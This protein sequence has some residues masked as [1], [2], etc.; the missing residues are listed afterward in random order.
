MALSD[1]VVEAFTRTDALGTRRGVRVAWSAPENTET[2]VRWQFR[3]DPG[4]WG[5]WEV[6]GLLRSSPFEI[7]PALTGRYELQVLDQQ[8]GRDVAD[9][10]FFEVPVAALVESALE[11]P[12]PSGLELIGPSGELLGSAVAFT[13]RDLKIRWNAVRLDALET[14]GLGEAPPDQLLDVLE[15]RIVGPTG[16]LLR[17][18]LLPIEA[19]EWAYTYAANSEDQ[20]LTTDPASA[21]RT[22]RIEL[23]WKD[24]TGR[25]GAPAVLTVAHTLRLSA[26]GDIDLGAV[27]EFL[28]VSDQTD[29]ELTAALEVEQVLESVV[30]DGPVEGASLLVTARDT[31]ASFDFTLGAM[32]VLRYWLRVRLTDSP[33]TVLHERHFDALT[34][35]DAGSV[36]TTSAQPQIEIALLADDLLPGEDRYTIELSFEQLDPVDGTGSASEFVALMSGDRIITAQQVKR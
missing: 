25:L 7:F 17:T 8:P 34:F 26:T 22:V 32:L 18:V 1:L 2:F 9:Y 11:L 23:R 4:E 16:T 20:P 5:D 36:L 35:I 33:F 30:I 14:E 29:V 21:L 3:A 28:I 15:L 31:L 24:T 6:S 19:T 13:G 12:K 10:G 27:N